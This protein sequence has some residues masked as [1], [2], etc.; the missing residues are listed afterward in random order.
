[1]DA[2]DAVQHQAHAPAEVGLGMIVAFRIDLVTEIEAK[3]LIEL[4]RDLQVGD[5]Q[6][7]RIERR[8]HA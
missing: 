3:V 1:M 6:A 2:R 8:S 5:H 4:D 7:D